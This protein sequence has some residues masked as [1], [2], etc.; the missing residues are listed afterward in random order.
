MNNLTKELEGYPVPEIAAYLVAGFT[1][2][3]SLGY[4]CSR[5]ALVPKNLK[6]ALDNET[7]VTAAIIKGLDRKH[8]A[9][10][11]LVHPLSHCIVP[12]W[13]Q[14]RRRMDHGT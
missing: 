10:P 9:G 8:M 5:F 14:S 2:G 1:S 6:S 11:F 4:T 12:P 7:H 13:A 3:F